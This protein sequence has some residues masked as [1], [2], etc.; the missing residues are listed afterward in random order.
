MQA[1]PYVQTHTHKLDYKMC[2][3]NQCVY[4][5]LDNAIFVVSEV[6]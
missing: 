3:K 2:A 4:I 1:T 5:N 6:N